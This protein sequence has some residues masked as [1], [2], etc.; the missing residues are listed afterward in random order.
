MVL[1]YSDREGKSQLYNLV[2]LVSIFLSGYL[3]NFLTLFRFLQL[4]MGLSLLCEVTGFSLL[5]ICLSIIYLS[6][7]LSVTYCLPIV[8]LALCFLFICHLLPQKYHIFMVI[9]FINLGLEFLVSTP[10]LLSFFL[11]SDRISYVS[12]ASAILKFYHIIIP[13]SPRGSQFCN[14]IFYP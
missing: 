13:T 6:A 3:L 11:T 7:Y 12:V 4:G 1:R 9:I 2:L 14:N 10:V 8:H 5:L